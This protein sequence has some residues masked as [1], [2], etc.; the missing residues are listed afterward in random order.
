VESGLTSAVIGIVLLASVLAQ[1]QTPS[2]VPPGTEILIGVP[3]I[4]PAGLLE[5]LKT[6]LAKNA[7]VAEAYLALIYVKREGQ[8][9]HLLLFLRIDD[10]PNFMK[11]LIRNDLGDASGAFLGE[12]ES[13]DILTEETPPVSSTVA[14]TVKP[15]YVRGK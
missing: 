11:E 5:A 15:F 4:I 6:R 8:V 12:G 9:P 7:D 10:V 2:T 1:A 14:K 13:I 3:K